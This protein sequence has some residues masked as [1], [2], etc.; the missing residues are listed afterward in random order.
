MIAADAMR[1]NHIRAR[2]QRVIG[3]K[4]DAAERAWGHLRDATDVV[5]AS[6]YRTEN[7]H[8]LQTGQVRL[9][10]WQDL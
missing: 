10:R 7:S 3:K 8:G 1:D 5:P 2:V 6:G 4:P 9:R